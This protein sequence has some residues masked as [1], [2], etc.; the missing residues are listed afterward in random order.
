MKL[1]IQTRTLKKDYSF[2]DVL[3]NSKELEEILELIGS[4]I[5]ENE[6]Y[7]FM[8]NDKNIY[9]YKTTTNRKDYIGREIDLFLFCDENVD[10]Q[11]LIEDLNVQEIDDRIQFNSNITLPILEKEIQT[12]CIENNQITKGECKKK[13]NLKPKEKAYLMGTIG[14]LVIVAILGQKYYPKPAPKSL[15]KEKNLST[16]QEN[17]LQKK[18]KNSSKILISENNESNITKDKNLSNVLSK[19]IN[20]SDENITEKNIS[21][22]IDKNSSKSVLV[23]ENSESNLTK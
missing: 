7:K 6:V 19:E 21:I 4:Y 11:K 18:E 22:Q 2:F 16:K 8:Y 20:K 14:V 10:F 12:F 1:T 17:S 9:A 23:S 3:G 13:L 5:S 15:I